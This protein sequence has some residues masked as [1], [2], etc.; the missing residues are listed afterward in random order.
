ME[1]NK[2]KT[3]QPKAKN[4]VKHIHVYIFDTIESE[5]PQGLRIDQRIV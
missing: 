4:K 2:K 3:K 1:T 5:S